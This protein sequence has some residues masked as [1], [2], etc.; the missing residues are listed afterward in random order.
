[1]TPE[2]DKHTGTCCDPLLF[3]LP[4]PRPHCLSGSSLSKEKE[5]RA[6]QLTAVIPATLEVE[7]RRR[8]RQTFCKTP[9]QKKKKRL[10]EEKTKGTAGRPSVFRYPRLE[11]NPGSAV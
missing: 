3:L 11:F 4:W 2:G 1:V 7:M 8:L 10:V 6:Q 9:S 5:S